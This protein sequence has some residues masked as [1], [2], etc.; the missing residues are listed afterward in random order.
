MSEQFL[1]Y[2]DILCGGTYVCWLIGSKLMSFPNRIMSF[3]MN[4]HHILYS[5][6]LCIVMFPLILSD[7]PFSKAYPFVFA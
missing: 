7:V 2:S 3:I 1:V 5:G 6:L 4:Q